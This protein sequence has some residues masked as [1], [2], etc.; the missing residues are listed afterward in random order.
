MNTQGFYN[1]VNKVD[2]DTLILKVGNHESDDMTTIKDKGCRTQ[3]QFDTAFDI[4]KGEIE[5]GIFQ[6]LSNDPF[7]VDY[8]GESYDN[9]FRLIWFSDDYMCAVMI[10]KTGKLKNWYKSENKIK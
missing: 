10:T 5:K 3:A 8:E 1:A 4:I 2:G 6:H 7:K 9:T